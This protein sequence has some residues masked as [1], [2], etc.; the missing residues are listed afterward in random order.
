MIVYAQLLVS[1][2]SHLQCKATQAVE[3]EA[4]HGSALIDGHHQIILFNLVVTNG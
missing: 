3:A 4:Y 1:L 2:Q